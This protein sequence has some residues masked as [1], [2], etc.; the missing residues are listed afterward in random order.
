[1]HKHRLH[2]RFTSRPTYWAWLCGLCLLCT[3]PGHAQTEPLHDFQARFEVT[4]FGLT[5]G[6]AQQRL[7]CQTQQCILSAT[8]KPSGMAKLFV[9]EMTR[10]TVQLR[11]SPAGLDWQGYQKIT[12]PLDRPDQTLKTVTFEPT[13]Q[14]PPQ[15]R[16]VEKSRTWPKPAR[17]FDLLSIAY[18]IQHAR[19]NQLPLDE[20]HLLDTPGVEP[21]RLESPPKPDSLTLANSDRVMKAERLEFK[22]S[23]AYV[24][25]WLLKEQR[26]FPARIEIEN[27]ETNKTITFL[28]EELSELL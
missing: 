10:E 22:T 24:T 4:A 13:G 1:M 3:S 17:V 18:A 7:Q 27:T 9:K 23:R 15:I 25:V 28:L 6:H 8:A 2:I 16:Y 5:L 20:L 12:S 19:L 14:N 21:L 26:F 11:P